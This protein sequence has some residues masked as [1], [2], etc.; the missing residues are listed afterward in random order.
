MKAGTSGESSIEVMM[1]PAM[2]YDVVSDVRRMGEWSP[3]CRQCEWVGGATGPAVGAQFK[4]TNRRGP[5]RW[6]TTPRVVAAEPGREFAFV[7][8]H[9][10]HDATKWS[11]RF[12]PASGGTK[13]TESFEVLIDVPWY[14]TLSERLLMGV[15]DRKAD[16][17]ANM[18]ETLERLKAA[19]EQHPAP[20]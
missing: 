9:R 3:E 1:S 4:G 7:T 17:E 12:E 6:S 2:L 13:V 16:L 8:S 19:A 10:G 15:K 14:F 18:A 5:A 20:G 11:Y